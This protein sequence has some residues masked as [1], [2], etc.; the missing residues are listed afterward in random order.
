M[1][2]GKDYLQNYIH[3]FNMNIYKSLG[4]ILLG[5]IYNIRNIIK[6]Y[7]RYWNICLGG[8]G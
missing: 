1:G 2:F 7:G 3:I 5:N 6:S 8:N 4:E